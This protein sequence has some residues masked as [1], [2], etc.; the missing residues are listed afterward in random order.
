MDEK[1][2]WGLKKIGTLIDS[3]VLDRTAAAVD[4]DERLALREPDD[5]RRGRTDCR[6]ALEQFAAEFQDRCH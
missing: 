3:P 4:Y 2:V 1:G 6:R 5:C